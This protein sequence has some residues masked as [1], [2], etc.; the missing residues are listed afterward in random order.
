MMT[1]Q[2]E[3]NILEDKFTTDAILKNKNVSKYYE[4]VDNLEKNKNS[5]N[6]TDNDILKYKYMTEVSKDLSDLYS[7]KRN[8]ENSNL[9]DKEKKVKVRKV[10]KEINN[11]VEER[12][13]NVETIN[14][15]SKVAKIGD[16][17]Y[18]KYHGEWTKLSDDEKEKNKK[19][20]LKSY[21]DF[22]NKVYNETEKQRK[23]GDLKENQ[24][25]KN[26]SKSEILLKSNY[27]NKE[28]LALY[29]N[30]VSST[31][32]KVE[33]AVE[34]LNMP[35]D[36]YLNYKT[37][38]FEN[39]KDKDGETISGTKKQKVYNY[40]NS[41]DNV[42][43]IYKYMIVKMEGINDSDGD[44]AIINYVNKS[45]KFNFEERKE[46]LKTLGFKVDKYG[47]V[48]NMI[49]IPIKSKIK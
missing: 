13:D 1:P 11:I 16:S 47:N 49:F 9:S 22:K 40:V 34:K 35:I 3:N 37:N 28:K 12:L 14:S 6:A 4:E 2:A 33:V 17:Q 45:Q 44:K 30:Y 38:Q 48:E 25:L 8:I 23:S 26:T 20:S 32:K 5:E 29:K 36:V 42:D 43:L 19:I 27:S 24:Q 15:N 31:D 18:Y 10:Q 21:A 46:A 7:E 39:D 41:L